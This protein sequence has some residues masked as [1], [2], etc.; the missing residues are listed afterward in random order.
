M[1]LAQ[2]QLHVALSLANFNAWRVGGPAERLYQPKNKED[3]QQFLANLSQEEPLTWLGLGS[4]L[5]IRDGGIRGTVVL[6]QGALN[7]IA[8]LEPTLI[9]LEAGVACGTA[10]RFC[11]RQ[12]LGGLEFLAGIPGTIGGALAMNAGA[13]GSETWEWVEA[14]ETVTRQGQALLRSAKEYQVAYRQVRPPAPEGFVAG[15]FRLLKTEPAAS[16]Q[17]IKNLLAHRSATQPINLPNCGSVFRNPPEHYAAQL[18]ESCGLKGLRRGGAMVSPKH[19]N[20]IVNDQKA[21]AQDIEFLIQDIALTVKQ[22]H[23]IELQREVHI[24]GEAHAG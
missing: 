7:Q 17:R 15:Y 13:H 12:G 20:F 18:I 11:A 14:C 24:I 9:R 16:L 1:T 8:L 22:Q 2:G 23:G 10:A 6:M 5:L 19:A 21:S 4:N 3:L